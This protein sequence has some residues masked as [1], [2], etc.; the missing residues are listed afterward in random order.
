[1]TDKFFDML[2]PE[3]DTAEK[4]DF[5]NR[6]L[7]PE[8]HAGGRPSKYRPEYAEQAYKLFLLNRDTTDAALAVFFGVSESTVNLWK[9]EYPEFSE[10]IWKGRELA[11][12]EVAH[13]LFKRAH[14]YKKK[15]TKVF[16]YKGNIITKDIEEEVEPDTKA[17]HLWLLNRSSK[18]WGKNGITDEEGNLH[19]IVNNGAGWNPN[20]TPDANES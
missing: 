8:K 2:Q 20:G 17:H 7:P 13:S 5:R 15:V 11:D 6:I 10:S 14:G 1:M 9:E 3:T 18:Q 16:C 12:V 4:E 19:I